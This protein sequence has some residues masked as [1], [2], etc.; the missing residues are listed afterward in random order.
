MEYVV[1]LKD[2]SPNAFSYNAYWEQQEPVMRPHRQK[3]RELFGVKV[4]GVPVSPCLT[5]YQDTLQRLS[6]MFD[7]QDIE[8]NGIDVA[9]MLSY[10]TEQEII[11]EL[12]EMGV[13]QEIS[14]SEIESLIAE[15]EWMPLLAIPFVRNQF[16]SLRQLEETPSGKHIDVSAFS[17]IDYLRGVA[18]FDKY[19][20]FLDK[21]AERAKDLAIL[22][23]AVSSKESKEEIKRKFVA[24]ANSRFRNR[25]LGMLAMYRSSRD[26]EKRQEL[27]SKM[28][29]LNRQIRRLRAIWKNYAYW[30]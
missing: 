11:D 17:T 22:H 12:N 29:E 20:Y 30:E 16:S 24:L 13:E 28:E 6:D 7:F 15:R 10:M 2:I 1:E 27:H 25:A 21:T 14:D 19:R 26:G 23:S 3:A 8:D 5:K 4:D 9:A 18:E